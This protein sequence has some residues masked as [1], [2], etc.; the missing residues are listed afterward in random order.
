[1]SGD[2]RRVQGD[3][4]AVSHVFAETGDLK[5]GDTFVARLADKTRHTLRVGAIYTRAAGLGDV[6]LAD[7]PAPTTAIFVTGSR[8]AL[9]R[10]AKD[11]DGLEVLTRAEYRTRVHAI[12]QENSWGVWMIVGL[13]ALFAALALINTA[14]MAT[15]ERRVELATIRLLGGTRG[16]RLRTAILETIPTTLVALLAGAAVVAISVHGIPLGLTGIPLAIPATTLA[17]IAAG[18]LALGLLTALATNLKR[19]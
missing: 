17:A 5:V 7:A 3:T 18:A 14:R 1:M 19:T 13:A 12:G 4:V 11:R 16:Q 6:V 10:Y 15:S 8:T 9:D 2:L